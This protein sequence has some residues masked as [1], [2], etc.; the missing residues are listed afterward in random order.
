MTSYWGINRS[1]I[2]AARPPIARGVGLIDKKKH[3]PAPTDRHPDEDAIPSR[4]GFLHT[5]TA[6]STQV[7]NCTRTPAPTDRHPDEDAISIRNGFLHTLTALKPPTPNQT[8]PPCTLPS[9]SPHQQLPQSHSPAP[10]DRHP[11]EDEIPS[12]NGFLH[13]LTAPSTQVSN[14]I[15]VATLNANHLTDTSYQ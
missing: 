13:T 15:R 11:D 3:T 8:G 7:S 5:L 14:C 4:N 6:P 9:A 10:T 12:R 1:T 2:P